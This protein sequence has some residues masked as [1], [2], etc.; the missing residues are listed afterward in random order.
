MRIQH[1]PEKKKKTAID[2]TH[3]K[4]LIFSQYVKYN[5]KYML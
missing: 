3:G 2:L 4:N 5:V 1:I